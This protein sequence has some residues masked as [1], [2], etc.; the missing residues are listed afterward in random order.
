[1]QW[2][3]Y[4]KE[5]VYG[6]IMALISSIVYAPFIATL[7]YH[8]EPKVFGFFATMLV[9]FTLLSSIGPWLY[10][11]YL[12]GNAVKVSTRQLP[13]IFALLE[14]H[15]QKLGLRT[16][17]D[18][19]VVQGGGVLNAFAMRCMSRDY[20]LMYSDILELAYQE[21]QDAVSFVIGH[22]LGHI[23]RKHTG[24]LKRV[25]LFPARL[26]PFLGNAYSRACEYTCDAIGYALCPEG[27]IK[28]LLV[29]AVGKRVYARVNSD[30]W[31]FERGYNQTFAQQICELFSTHPDLVNRV[32][33]V[34]SLDA[35]ASAMYE[36][37]ISLD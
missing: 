23:K 7:I 1:M 22:E 29:L 15:S 9:V 11:G 37:G 21:G 17:P 2:S 10:V 31:V 4:Y 12:Q 6:V 19:Y 13:E 36:Q 30:E 33:R 8:G 27:A 28:G 14:S 18:M 5:R 26:I 25:F 24:F 34:Q 35:A 3:V 16:V 20:I 32:K